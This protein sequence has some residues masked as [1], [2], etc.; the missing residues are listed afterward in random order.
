MQGDGKRKRVIP[1]TRIQYG[2]IIFVGRQFNWESRKREG[3]E[4]E[5]KEGGE[6]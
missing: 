5:G 6:I 2:I 4:D 1:K 3:R